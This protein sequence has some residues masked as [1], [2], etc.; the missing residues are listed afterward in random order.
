MKKLDL[1]VDKDGKKLRC[2]YTTGSCATG[3]SKASAK[4]LLSKEKIEKIK[5]STPSS[6]ELEL[7]VN[8]IDISK[9]YVISS[10]TKDAGD[11]IDVTDKI[12]IFSKVSLREDS[13]IIITGGIGI[14]IITKKGIYGE[15]GDYAINPTPKKMIETELRK[16]DENQG[17]N[18]EIFSPQGVEI[19]KKTFNKNI[20][21]EG[22]ISIIGTTGIVNPM[23]EDAFLKSIYMEIKSIAQNEGTDSTLALT[24]GNYGVDFSKNKLGI[25][26]SVKVSNFLGKSLKYAYNLGFRKFYLIGHIGKFSKVSMGVFNTHNEVA[27]LRLEAFVFYLAMES[28]EKNHFFNIMKLLSAEEAVEYLVNNNLGWIIEKMEK[29]AES[30]V[31]K[32]L[33]DD[34]IDVKVK[35]YSMNRGVNFD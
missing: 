5:I 15:I 4:M 24:P 21:I 26:T 14:G 1:Y 17:F 25:H 31:L 18:V 29:G 11:D 35:M 10:I 19:S 2:G 6:V 32:Y 33:K 12:E 22:G 27:D 9:D 28:V 34:N 8:N 7:E 16:L 3:A 20:G 30:R 23:S 13:K